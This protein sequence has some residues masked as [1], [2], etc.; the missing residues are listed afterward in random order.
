MDFNADEKPSTEV[1]A[2]A[3]APVKDDSRKKQLIENF[4]QHFELPSELA[5]R[6]GI[7]EKYDLVVLCDDSGSMNT[8]IHGT[9]TNRWDELRQMLSIIIDV[10]AAFDSN[11]V[12]VYFLK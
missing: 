6:I 9:T 10:Y 3:P 7:L 5:N 11:G 12:D 8:P 1:K 2:S 4:S